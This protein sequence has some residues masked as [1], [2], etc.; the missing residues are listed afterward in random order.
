MPAGWR[1]WAVIVSF[2]GLLLWSAPNDP[3]SFKSDV[4]PLLEKN[5]LSCHGPAQQMSLLD[6][7][8]RAAALK[9]GQ[10]G[11]PAIVPGSA[12]KSPLYRRVT[13]QD[14]PPMPLGG[15][16]SDAEIATLQSWIDAGATSPPPIKPSAATGGW[17]GRPL[18]RTDSALTVALSPL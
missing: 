3:V 12:A 2:G 5:C 15:K 17:S 4:A 8:S 18:A 11:G 14:Q 1:R 10:K 13:G 16:L 9:G 6:L 7:S